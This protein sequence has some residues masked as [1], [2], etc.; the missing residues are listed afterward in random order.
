MSDAVTVA[1]H[2]AETLGRTPTQTE[3]KAAGVP[4]RLVGHVIYLAGLKPRQPGQ[5]RAFTKEDHV[6]P[7]QPCPVVSAPVLDA[8]GQRVARGRLAL[9]R[10][11]DRTNDTLSPLETWIP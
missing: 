11:P 2:L 8:I 1:K 6:P 9:Y 4:K 10:V 7:T 5:P 3:L